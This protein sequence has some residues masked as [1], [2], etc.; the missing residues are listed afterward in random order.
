MQTTMHRSYVATLEKECVMCGRWGKHPLGACSKLEDMSQE[1]RWNM[2]KGTLCK[3]CLKTGYIASKCHAPPVCKRCNKYHHTLLHIKANPKME[4]TKKVDKDITYTVPS[5]WSEEVLV[6]TCWVKI[7][8]PDDSIAQAIASLDSA[9]LTSLIMNHLVKKLRLNWCHSN[10]KINGVA[11]FN[12]CP[13]GTVNLK[14]AGVR[15]VGN[16]I[17]VEA[18][19]LLK[20]MTT[21]P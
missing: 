16:Q 3:N 2:V 5:K 7:L 8:A 10:F 11:G 6:M 21:C 17:E 1:E 18:F 13:R 19:I 12:V 15:G 20:Y 9:A 14:V 4:G